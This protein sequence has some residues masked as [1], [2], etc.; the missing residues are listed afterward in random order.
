MDIKE[1]VLD[2]LSR[3]YD[4]PE[5]IDVMTLNYV[6]AGYIDSLEM[7]QFMS[8]IEYEF[9]IMFTDEDMENPDIKVTGKLIDLVN[10]KLNYAK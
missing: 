4:L 5:D 8:N 1:Y 10:S 7:I 9:N 2:Y 3:E 6:E